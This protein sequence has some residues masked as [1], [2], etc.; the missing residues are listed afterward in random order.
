MAFNEVLAE[1]RYEARQRTPW[2]VGIVALF[3]LAFAAVAV[4]VGS[5]AHS[6]RPTMPDI[7]LTSFAPAVIE[8]FE[9]VR[10][11]CPE[12]DQAKQWLIAHTPRAGAGSEGGLTY[13]PRT[14]ADPGSSTADGA[15]RVVLDETTDNETWKQLAAAV[16]LDG[17]A[18]PATVTENSTLPDPA[19]PTVAVFTVP[20][21]SGTATFRM[22]FTV[23][24][25]GAVLTDLEIIGGDL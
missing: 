22:R 1:I 5:R 9:C 6:A 23:A 11:E 8:V 15:R 7:P 2:L 24:Q 21:A 13:T 14:A 18:S 4:F 19:D 3:V 10:T 16:T 25:Q 20:T 17:N 12:A